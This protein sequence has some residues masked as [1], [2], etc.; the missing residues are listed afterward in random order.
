MGTPLLVVCMGVSG[1]GKST[2]S[3]ALAT[4]MN[5]PFVEADDFHSDESRAQMRSGQPLSD[6]DREPWMFAIVEQLRELAARNQSCVM[7]HSALRRV[8][9]D[10]LRNAG[11]STQFLFLD[12]SS[13]MI[14][15]RLQLRENHFMPV[16]LLS[17]QYRA[18][19]PPIDEPDVVRL[20]AADTPQTLLT[21]ALTTL[22]QVKK[23]SHA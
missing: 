17:S 12:C 11:M 1:S 7:A 4:E 2:L 15:E 20:N 8:H 23:V 3:R 19:E 6:S 13:D 5:W 10:M 22:N 18:L 16:D 21:V 14:A 9:R